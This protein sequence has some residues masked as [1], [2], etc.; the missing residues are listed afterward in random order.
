MN[1][2][3]GMG[4]GGGGGLFPGR[5]ITGCIFFIYRLMGL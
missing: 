1:G 5:L 4:A 3:E 2:G